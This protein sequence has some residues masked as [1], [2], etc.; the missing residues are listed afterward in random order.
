MI[1]IIKK[2]N[3]DVF[4]ISVRKN[5]NFF[6]NGV[7][8]HNCC[9]IS[10]RPYTFCNL[11]TIDVSDIDSQEELNNRAKAAA[12]IGTLQASYTDF[13]YLR[14]IWQKNSEED[15]LIGVSMTGIASGLILKD[16]F[17][18]TETAKCVVDENKRVANL[19][20]IN[21]AKR[22]TTLKPEGT[23]SL[24]AGTSSGIHAFH[25]PYYIRRMRINKNEELYTY[26][27]SILDET[28]I[29][30][31]FFSPT[32]TAVLS[33]PI[34][35][36][37]TSIFR[38]ETEIDLLERMKKF[39]LEWI[40]SGYISGANNNNVSLTVSIKKENWDSVRDWAW[41][42]KEF[43]TGISVLP[44]DGGS[45]PQLPFEDITEDVYNEM[46]AKLDGVHIDLRNIIEEIDT[47]N[48][49]GEQACSGGGCEVK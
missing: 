33:M 39:Q 20:G 47:T 25:A 11:C 49:Q 29:E 6:A 37:E 10:L 46:I 8:V 4:D 44:Y 2:E 17:S 38:N 21:S 43:Y 3:E 40:R 42:N 12:F 48:L 30:D 19:I 45:Y 1:R 36:P 7:L 31:E 32:T 23:A 41:N 22:S 27:K 34:K 13:H 24:V 16:T 26:L 15:A 5:N 35:S 18:I 14:D 28:F 9:E